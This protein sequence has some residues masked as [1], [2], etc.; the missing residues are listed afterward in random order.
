MEVIVRLYYGEFR[1]SCGI[2]AVTLG[3]FIC[4]DIDASHLN[5]CTEKSSF[6]QIKLNVFL[7][8]GIFLV[9]IYRWV[10]FMGFCSK[11]AI[12]QRDR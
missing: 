1:H 12:L 8:K 6:P 3:L 4:I 7:V 2:G 9:L 10:T 11:N 5:P